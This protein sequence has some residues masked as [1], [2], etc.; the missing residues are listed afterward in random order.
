MFRVITVCGLGVGSSLILKM[1]V[2]TAMSQLGVDCVI[3]HW[4]MG[5]IKG[6]K[7]DMIVTTESFRENFAGQDN[8]VFVNNIMDVNEVKEN[9]SAFLD[10][11]S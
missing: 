6:Q 8:V 4:D 5:T 9:I 10:E 2:D 11:K 1:T 3:E 7:C